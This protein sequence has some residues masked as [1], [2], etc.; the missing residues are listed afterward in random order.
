MANPFSGV[1]GLL[2]LLSITFILPCV[3][4]ISF[5]IPRFDSGANNILYQGAARPNVGAV[6]FNSLTFV[7]QVGRIIFAES[8]PIWDS[9]TREVTSFTS[10]FSFIIDTQGKASSDYSAGLAFFLAPVGSEIPPNSAGGF[11]GLFNTTTIDSS[12]NQVVLVE[13]DTFSNTDWDPEVEHVGININSISSVK[14][15]PWNFSLYSEDTADAWVSYNATTRN[16]S[17]TWSYQ[18]SSSQGSLSHQ[19]DL[20]EILPETAIVGFSAATSHRIERHQLVSWEFNSSLERKAIKEKN[21]NRIRIVIGVAVP[22]GILVIAGCIGF[23]ILLCWKRRKRSY[24]YMEGTFGINDDLERGAGPRRFSYKDLVAA[25]NNFS[26]QRKLG[27]G[28]FGAVY[29]GY[30]NELD[31]TIAVKKISKGSRQGEKEYVTEVKVISQLRHRNLV[32]LIGFCHDGGMFLLVYVFMSNGSLDSHLF[33]KK[34]P[35]NWNLRYKAARGVASALLYI[36]EEWEQC[37]VHRDIKP[38]NIML[39]SNFNVKLGDFGLARLMD[40]E[41][42]PRTTGLAGTLGYMAPEYIKTGR[43]SRASDVY[44][45]GVVA[46]EIA[47]GRRPVDPIEEN[48]QIGLVEWVWHLYGSGNLLSS[49]D[50]RMNAEFDEK[51]MECLMIVGLW[52]AHPDSNLRPSIKQVIQV[53]DFDMGIPN[54]PSKMPIPTYHEHVASSSSREP[55]LTN[56]S[57]EVGR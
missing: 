29:K 43:A 30:I 38:S 5:N 12:G 48:S 9:E 22:L 4:S 14:Y 31:T 17:V 24:Q 7:C 11:L 51:Q 28:G 36:H 26:S 10:H 41:L 46:L 56:S 57:L 23:K 45:F 33:G 18:N 40:H 19:I 8:V 54:L 32:Q 44:S 47:T 6:E 1:F 55:I 13:F 37:V 27:E 39:D 2:Q 3:N 35:L 25:T 52:C 42:G 50:K 16:L 53:L 34:T 49:V 20:T 15:A 21:T